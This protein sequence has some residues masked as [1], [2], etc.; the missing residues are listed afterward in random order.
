LAT[1]FDETIQLKAGPVTLF[2]DL[3]IPEHSQGVVVFAHGSGSS[4]HSPRNRQV[5]QALQDVGL[6]TLL[7]DLLTSE[8]EAEEVLTLH[9]RFDIELL[10]D[11][12]VGTTNWL[13]QTRQTANLTVGYFGA[14]TGAGAALVA[15]ARLPNRG[16]AV[17]S[18][19]GRP[20]LAGRSLALVQA[21][22]LLI[23]GSLDETVIPL[24][25]QALEKIRAKEKRLV[26][27]P[28]ASHLFKEPG[29]L[30]EVSRLA[31][32]WFTQHLGQSPLRETLP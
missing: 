20:D 9:F 24:N 14:S 31:A 18:R 10:A 5:A 2:G 30:S 11:R 3:S 26:I 19:G 4:R 23:V 21:P 13:S 28:G 25:Q 12:F 8:E 27:V 16:A 22:T 15:A 7:L 32:D 17:V 6:A 1:H 29:K